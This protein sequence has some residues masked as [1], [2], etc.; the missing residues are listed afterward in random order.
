MEGT[1]AEAGGMDAG[2]GGMAP[3]DDEGKA[4]G[5][6][7]A[8]TVEGGGALERISVSFNFRQRRKDLDPA[9][10]P[11]HEVVRADLPARRV[12]PPGR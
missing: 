1:E 11:A 12:R 4:D 7:A 2:S 10:A 3:G 9:A 6:G 8:A 5:D